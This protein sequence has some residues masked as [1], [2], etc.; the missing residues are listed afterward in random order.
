MIACMLSLSCEA[1]CSH[2]QRLLRGGG[3]VKVRQR[4]AIHF[5]VKY[6][7]LVPQAVA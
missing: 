5:L 3:I 4:V 1:T 7:K 6:R 2:L